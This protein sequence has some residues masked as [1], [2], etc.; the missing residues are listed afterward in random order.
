MSSGA[1]AFPSGP[2]PPA[3]SAAPTAPRRAH[4]GPWRLVGGSLDLTVPRVV[5]ILN[6]TPDSFSDGG[7][8]SGPDDAL[9]RAERMIEE[10]VAIL[11]V[12]GE[13]TRPGASSVPLEEELRRVVPTVEALAR[14]FDVPVSVDTRK[15]GVA[16][17]ALDAG[18]AI[19]NDVSGLGSD[20]EMGPLVA[21]RGAGVVL[22][23]MRGEPSEMKELARY[24]D[25]V[26]DVVEE[27]EGVVA[28]ATAAGVEREAVVVDPGFGFAKKAGHNVTLLGRLDELSRLG[29]PVLVGPSRKRFLGA[30]LEVPPAQRA[31]GTAAA[32]VL[33]Y[34]RGARL[35]RVHDVAPTVQALQVARTVSEGDLQAALDDPER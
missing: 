31:A 16:R 6:L 27:L 11:D 19:V 18:A 29:F 28:R 10:G 25:V 4:T 22:M 2:P 35:F 13:S 33:A 3:G 1:S 12:G 32:C 17:S 5:G 7:E 8:L 20:P 24:G 30:I 9:R 21:E 14:R 15:A 34:L 23:H 26:H